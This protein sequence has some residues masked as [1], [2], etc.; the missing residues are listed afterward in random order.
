MVDPPPP[1]PDPMTAPAPPTDRS[2][3]RRTMRRLRREYVAALAPAMRR[4][5]EQKLA[6]KL[7]GR[8]PHEGVVALYHA[9]GDEIDPAA[10]VVPAQMRGLTLALPRVDAAAMTMDFAIWA[11]GD[12]VETSL[13]QIHQPLTDRPAVRPDIILMPL[14]AADHAGN[15]LGQGAG[16]Y[17]RAL[18]AFAGQGPMPRCIGLAW[19]VQ[20]VPVLPAEPWDMPLDA[21]ATPDAWI[22]CQDV[23]R[24]G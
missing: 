6:Q 23:T 10:F 20:I 15:R 24:A 7:L 4:A 14:V 13:A 18:A 1:C 2:L 8:M 16:Y 3:L 11:P 17:D 12:S 22:S 21:I 5:A 9:V 19:D